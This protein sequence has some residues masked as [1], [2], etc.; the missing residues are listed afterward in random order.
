MIAF[1]T[2]NHVL[3]LIKSVCEVVEFPS[4]TFVMRKAPA[5]SAC[6]GD[7]NVY[8]EVRCPGSLRAMTPLRVLEI[9]YTLV[10]TWIHPI[11]GWRL[12]RFVAT[13]PADLLK[14]HEACGNPT[15]PNRDIETQ[16]W[17][18]AIAFPTPVV[19]PVTLSLAPAKKPLTRNELVILARIA[20]IPGRSLMTKP[21]LA[22]ALGL[23]LMPVA[24]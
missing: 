8:A 14:L 10:E 16:E 2:L 12:L 13:N 7:G 9:E 11:K 5:S 22:I 18:Q 17:L 20:K 6:F 3:S 24:A 19:T 23:P 4:H 21:E 15:I 1:I